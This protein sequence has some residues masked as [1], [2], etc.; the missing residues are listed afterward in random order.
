[1]P[2]LNNDFPAEI[3]IYDENEQVVDI[4]FSSGEIIYPRKFNSI[5]SLSELTEDDI[6]LK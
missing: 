6:I 5:E 3:N 2:L 1:L 4:I